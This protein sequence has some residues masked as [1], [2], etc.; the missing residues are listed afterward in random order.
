MPDF[1]VFR[2]YSKESI[3][4]DTL[5]LPIFFQDKESKAVLYSDD[6]EFNVSGIKLI[7][8]YIDVIWDEIKLHTMSA[9]SGTA[10]LH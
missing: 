9:N 10:L 3:L 8:E 1:K 4:E 2:M 6:L 7:C 5:E